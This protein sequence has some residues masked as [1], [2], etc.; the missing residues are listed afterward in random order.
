MGI[1]EVVTAPRLPWQ[2]AYVERLIGSIR[3]KCLDHIIILKDHHLRGAPGRPLLG[4]TMRANCKGDAVSAASGPQ[5][6]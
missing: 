2:S 4:A 3:R 5:L 6:C 1:K